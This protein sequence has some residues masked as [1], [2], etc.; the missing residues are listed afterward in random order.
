MF[1][2]GTPQLCG[3][4]STHDVTYV[5]SQESDEYMT[6][7]DIDTLSQSSLI[8]FADVSS[9]SRRQRVKSIIR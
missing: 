8:S 3:M 5:K 6:D 1:V 7:D 2:S 4:V 9:L